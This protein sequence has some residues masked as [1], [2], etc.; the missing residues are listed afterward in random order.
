MKQETLQR[1]P[2]D[3]GNI[4][5]C[6]ALT[7]M[8]KVGMQNKYSSSVYWCT[9]VWIVRYR[10]LCD[11]L[12]AW[13]YSCLMDDT[14]I[15]LFLHCFILTFTFYIIFCPFYSWTT[16]SVLFFTRMNKHVHLQSLTAQTLSWVWLSVQCWHKQCGRRPTDPTVELQGCHSYH[17]RNRLTSASN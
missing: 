8:L 17:N 10:H 7:E 5:F 16:P 3:Y 6:P 12:T 9:T 15:A 11:K 1:S 13:L 4:T 14:L 2:G